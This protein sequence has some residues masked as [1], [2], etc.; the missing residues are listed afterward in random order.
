MS[1]FHL[2]LSFWVSVIVLVVGGFRVEMRKDAHQPR[3]IACR[4]DPT[5]PGM[6]A[7]QV[8]WSGTHIPGSPFLVQICATRSDLEQAASSDWNDQS[9]FNGCSA[10]SPQSSWFAL[11]NEYDWLAVLS[12]RLCS[13]SCGT[14]ALTFVLT[15]YSFLQFCLMLARD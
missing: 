2:M 8:M 11:P 3:T 14:F 12:N 10:V 7:I 5:E 6:Y 13:R 15:V 4:Y 1:A 9:Q